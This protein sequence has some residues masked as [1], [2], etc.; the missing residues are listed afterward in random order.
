MTVEAR[1]IAYLAIVSWP[2]PYTDAHVVL[3]TDRD[4]TV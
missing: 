1:V 2:V 3:I 4:S